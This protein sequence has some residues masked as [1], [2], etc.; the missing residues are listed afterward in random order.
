MKLPEIH[1]DS[2]ETKILLAKG[3]RSPKLEKTGYIQQ[4]RELQYAPRKYLRQIVELQLLYIPV[5]MDKINH[6]KKI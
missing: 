6:F 5:F 4:R 2:K 3:L 1:F